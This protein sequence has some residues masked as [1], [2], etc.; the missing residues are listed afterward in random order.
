MVVA[1]ANAKHIAIIAG[2]DEYLGT[3]TF[4]SNADT[5]FADTVQNADY[6]GV[7]G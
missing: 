5:A 7:D 6:C 1:A 4:I 3:M 2:T